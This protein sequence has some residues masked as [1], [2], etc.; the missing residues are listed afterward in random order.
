ML[1]RAALL[2]NLPD[3]EA[4]NAMEPFQRKEVVE[5]LVRSILTAVMAQAREPDEWEALEIAD[6]LGLLLVGWNHAAL[7]AAVKATVPVGDRTA[8]QNNWSRNEGTPREAEL[9]R[10]L[11]YVAGYPARKDY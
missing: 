5:N 8:N 3:D 1:D 11:D 7:S 9:R 6:A 10:A 2:G 4:F